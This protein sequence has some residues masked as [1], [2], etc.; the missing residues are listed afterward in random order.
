MNTSNII[1][2]IENR[3]AFIDRVKAFYN[4]QLSVLPEGKLRIVKHGDHIY[5]YRIV[6]CG[7]NN[8]LLLKDGEKHIANKLAQRSYCEALLRIADKESKLLK[9]VL[10]KYPATKVEDY[11]QTLSNERQKIVVPIMLTDDQFVKQW[12]ENPFEPKGFKEGES[13]FVTIKGERVRSK[14]EQIIADRLTARGIPYKYECPLERRS[15]IVHPD[16]TILRMSD[17]KEVYL[18]HLGKMGDERYAADAVRRVN[19]YAM[20]GIVLGDRLFVTMETDTVPLDV[21]M[22]DKLIEQELR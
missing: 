9:R 1:E 16:F 4:K 5:Y 6:D 19:E 18:E 11:Y 7:D 14:S 3:N 22:L 8:G 20:N 13:H 21:R 15:D 2:Q 10:E 12:L 17:R